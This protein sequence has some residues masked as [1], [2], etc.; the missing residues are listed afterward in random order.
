MDIRKGIKKIVAIGTGALMLG[1]TIIGA[2]AATPDLSNYPSPFIKDGKFDGTIV[3][4]TNAATQDVLGAID[5]ATSLQ[6]NLKEEKTVSYGTGAIDVEGDAT[7]ISKTSDG[8]E[9]GEYLSDVKSVLT[10]DD[11]GMLDTKTFS[12][13]KGSTDYN[14]YLRFTEDN[15]KVIYG[16]N[17]YDDV[18]TFLKFED[19]TIAFEYEL[20]F[21]EGMESDLDGNEAEDLHGERIYMFGNEFTIVDSRVDGDDL[22]L[23]L[24]AGE[25]TDTLKERETKTYT[26]G[27]KDYEVTVSIISDDEGSVKFD[28]N[29]ES[30]DRLYEGETDTLSDGTQIGVREVIPN[31]G[32]EINGD[33]YVEFYIG[34]TKV[35]L[36]DNNVYDDASSNS[37]KIE[38][39][40][41]SDADVQITATITDDDVKITNIKY[42]TEL[43][44]RRGDMYVAEG[45]SV[46]D[47]LDEVESMFAPGW[48]IKYM[49]LTEVDTNEV[50]V[51]AN[52]DD[53]Y[54]LRFTT[55]EGLEYNIPLVDVSG[56]FKLGD[57][58]DDLFIEYGQDIGL[59]DMFILNDNSKGNDAHTRIMRFEDVDEDD[60]QLTF[61]DLSGDSE[62]NVFYDEVTGKSDLIVGGESYPLTYNIGSDT[63]TIDGAESPNIVV[64]GGGI[65]TL[66]DLGGSLNM[67]LTTLA[68]DLDEGKS[69]EITWI[70]EQNG[71]EVSMTRPD[72]IEL[73]KRL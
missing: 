21:E 67:S 25:V 73:A 17:E 8:L 20:E 69:T 24:M 63:V 65:L 64:K 12:N 4:G 53:A 42:S 2:M 22:D 60:R 45:D 55:Q 29:G 46:R 49:G 41:L 37:V 28:I 51:V 57:D 34:S 23:T 52:G 16:E 36:S 59:D 10:E 44:A 6:Y 14:S 33:D 48:D 3:I 30:T 62:K 32:T 40:R 71:D 11:M 68:E 1:T 5:I 43:K 7:L 9:I 58:D 31:E 38:N 70:L 61:S 27:D 56:G 47:E 13:N 39:E 19:G 50:E 72:G 35:E 26:V 15:G 54:E 18:G 66:E